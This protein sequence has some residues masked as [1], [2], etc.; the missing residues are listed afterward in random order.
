MTKDIKYNKLMGG[1]MGLCV[2]DA[3]GVPV[4]FISRES[5]DN[6][7]VTNMIEYG[8]HNQPIGTWS[9]DSSL[10]FCLIESLCKDYDIS[11]IGKNFV[12]WKNNAY[13]TP[14]GTVF[15]IGNST[16]AAINKLEKGVNPKLS[17]G[18]SPDSNGNGSLMRIL[19]LAFI[20]CDIETIHEVSSITHAHPI[21][22]I[23]CGIY[24][25]I[26]KKVLKGQSINEAYKNMKASSKNYYLKKFPEQIK[27]F[28]RILDSDISKLP[29]N[30]IDSGGY[31]LNTL[32]ASLWCL[33]N[34][35]NYSD[36]VLTAVNLGDDADTTG[37]V[38]GGLAGIIYEFDSIPKNWVDK[39]VQKEEIINLTNK[40]FNAIKK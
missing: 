9:D 20:D 36:A 19:P 37:A 18:T 3:L 8:T 11:D 28:E 30:E 7:P 17:G 33:L 13:W 1:I 10:A 26:A 32:E 4:E 25:D 5:L 22:L 16:R 34:T 23:S 31:A 15:D 14:H 2:G 24:I 29:R 38:T 27:Y 12:K 40:F 6:N 35:D 21:S 39:L